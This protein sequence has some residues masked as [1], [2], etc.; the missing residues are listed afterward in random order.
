MFGEII[1]GLVGGLLGGDD[2]TTTQQQRMDPRMDKYVYGENGQGGL[3]G[4]A[5]N[6]YQKQMGQGGMNPLMTAGLEAQRQFL[7]S[8]QYGLGFTNLMGLGQNL[9]GGGVAG[10][11]FTSGQMPQMVDQTGRQ[12]MPVVSVPREHLAP[13]QGQQTGY[14][15]NPSILPVFDPVVAQGITPGEMPEESDEDIVDRY[16]RENKLGKYAENNIG[17]RNWKM[18]G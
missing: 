13:F 3:L 1:G 17:L 6:L 14:Y 2:Q 9:L 11:P 16:M 15:A 7:T 8:P 12:S 10:N 5:F 18:R 4:D